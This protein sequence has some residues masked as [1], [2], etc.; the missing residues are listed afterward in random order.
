MSATVR[1]G[2]RGLPQ[3][4]G[5]AGPPTGR[6]GGTAVPD[7]A[8]FAR[9]TSP[10]RPELLA[11]C[12]RMLG[13]VHDAED[14]VQETLIRAWRAYG[15]F[16]GRASLRTWLYRIATN[17]CLRALENRS[18]LPLPSG[19]GGPGD[20][21]ERPAPAQA[22][23]PWLQPVPDHLISTD[24]ADPASIADAR[25][26]VRLALIAALQHL[27]PR[28]RA[29][30]ILRDVLRWQAS[31]TADLL[32][33]TTTAVN[34]MLRRARTQLSQA[35]SVA[36]DIGEPTDPRQ[37]RLL[38]Q[39]AAAFENA[40]GIVLTRLLRADAVL[41]MPPSPT[42]FAGRDQI[43]PFLAARV[44]GRP[45]DFT[46]VRVAANG[47]PGFAAYLRDRDG[48]YRAHA[49][50]VLTLGATSIARIVSFNQPELFA[51]FALPPVLPR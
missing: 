47:Q 36:D 7:G 26:S 24:L 51:M 27:P 20:A 50:Q 16:E 42:W 17:S 48:R 33:T 40:D 1:E 11:H 37:R 2:P 22:E 49:V 45:G 46:M 4:H 19:L 43:V 8:E 31:E 14:Q 13:S 32:G 38:D 39:Y 21:A 10:L 28:Q 34:S 25:G 44:L 41:E 5:V 3:G 18:R 35:A 9:L 30:L 6:P 15:G 12:Y 29:V 23:V